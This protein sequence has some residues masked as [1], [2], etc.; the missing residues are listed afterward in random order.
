MVHC[1]KTSIYLYCWTMS[2]PPSPPVFAVSQSKGHVVGVLN[3]HLVRGTSGGGT[4]LPLA[5]ALALTLAL[6]LTLTCT[7]R[8]MST[9]RLGRRKS[10]RVIEHIPKKNEVPLPG[11]AT[12]NGSSFESSGGSGVLTLGSED[13]GMPRQE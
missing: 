4:S 9:G 3:F 13:L 7:S 5:L 12:T 6:T 1:K 11:D 10:L 8:E 2:I